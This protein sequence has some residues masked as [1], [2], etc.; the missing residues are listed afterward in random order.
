MSDVFGWIEAGGT[1]LV[2]GLAEADPGSNQRR[3]VARHRLPTGHPD[4]TLEAALAW[5]TAQ[6]VALRAIGIA[7]F[8]PL[9]L[10]RA[11]ANWGHITRTTKPG[12]SDT[13]CAA[14]SRGPSAARSG[15]RPMSTPPRWPRRAGRGPGPR[16]VRIWAR[17]ST[18]RSAPG[19]AAA[20]SAGHLLHGLSHPELG[21]IRL[22][23]PPR[24]RLVRRHLSVQRPLLEGLASG[25]A[26][27]A[28][29]G[30]SLSDLPASHPG[31][32]HHRL[33]S[34]AGGGQLPGDN[35]TR[36]DRAGGRATATR[37]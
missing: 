22:L 20:L 34:R 12:W 31:G 5:F 33:V 6:N 18:S 7:S 15:S 37:G 30:Q 28:R 9:Q 36:A 11:A 35:G 2:L 32:A 24:R 25:P 23:A 17:R 29:W 19:S 4:E 27:I 1:K 16:R 21:H 14:P 8:G 10:D 13:R 3:I 26:V